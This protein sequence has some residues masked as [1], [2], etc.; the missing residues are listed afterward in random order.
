MGMMR[1]K[2]AHGL[3]PRSKVVGYPVGHHG[4]CGPVTMGFDV[5]P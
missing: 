3:L 1:A 5:C 4:K 2:M